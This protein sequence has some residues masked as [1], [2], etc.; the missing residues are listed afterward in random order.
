[1]S[2]RARAPIAAF[3]M[4]TLLSAAR[5]QGPM[6]TQATTTAQPLAGQREDGVGHRRRDGRRAGFAGA[7]ASLAAADDVHVDARHLVEAQDP[8]V[9]KIALD[10]AA[11]LHRQLGVEGRAETEGEAGFDLGADAERVDADAAIDRGGDA[12]HADLPLLDGDLGDVGDDAPERLV[13][14]EAAAAARRH[15]AP[16]A[17]FHDH[18]EFNTL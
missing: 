8:V 6:Q 17:G 16:R 10:D 2:F 18:V 4:F 13:H 14:G 12:V 3:F 15:R 11:F 5:P 9:V 7:A 1:M